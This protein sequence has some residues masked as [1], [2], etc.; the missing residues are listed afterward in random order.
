MTVPVSAPVTA[1]QIAPPTALALGEPTLERASARRGPKPVTGLLIE[2]ILS[3]SLAIFC[4]VFGGQAIPFVIQQ[5]DE[6][7]PVWTIVLVVALYGSFAVMAVIGLLGRS[8]AP[9]SIFVSI[10][11]L[12]A[13]IT[14]PFATLDHTVVQSS[15]P[16]LW[17]ICNLVMAAAVSA[18]VTWIAAVYVVVVPA[19][20]FV[21]RQTPSGGNGAADHALLESFYAFLL[22]AA[23][24]IL[25]TLLRRAAAAVDS[26]QSAAV[27][28]YGDAVRQHA[29]EVERVEVDAIVHDG[30]LTTL[31]SAAK[32]DTTAARGLAA[33]MARA[34][35]ARLTSLTA[36][37]PTGDRPVLL[38][39]VRNRLAATLMTLDPTAELTPAEEIPAVLLPVDV[40]ETLA[41]AASQ[42]LV[43]SCQHAGPGASRLVDIRVMNG[44]AQITVIDDGVGFDT[45][46]PSERLGVRVSILER[47]RNVGAEASIRSAPGS[48]TRVTLRFPV[49]A[50]ASL[51]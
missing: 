10:A 23:I 17:Y 27:L 13:L 3:R 4:L 32:A 20:F 7:E 29:T 46:I 50:G 40:V 38:A 36:E 24:L 42:A 48:G 45:S 8:I 19:I 51:S 18:F 43:N 39:E 33:S 14:W 28:R 5:R 25:V 15:V 31:L 47:A 37:T 49:P 11:Y 9:A 21:V 1:P 41:D 26:A 30:V 35:M 16:W 34:S 6:L 2:R 22:G 44:A 12:A